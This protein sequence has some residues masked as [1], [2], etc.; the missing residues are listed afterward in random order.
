MNAGLRHWLAT[1]P[2]PLASRARKARRWRGAS[3]PL[4]KGV[5]VPLR[6]VYEAMRGIVFWVRRVFIAEPIFRSYCEKVGPGFRAGVFVHWVQGRGRIIIGSDVR[7]DGKSSFSFASR[8]SRDPTLTIG[9]R[10]GIGHQCSFAVGNRIDIGSDCRI[11]PGVTIFDSP[12]HPIDPTARQ[13]GA[14]PNQD[15]VRPVMIGNN[16]WIGTG[17]TIYPGVTIG[18]GS[19]ISAGAVVMN[20]VPPNTL[21]AGNPGRRIGSTLKQVALEE[22]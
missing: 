21:V 20:D 3:L 8:F 15:A 6:M 16:V 1:S 18:E 2:H 12:G 13:S 10:T 17:A 7:I 4:P 5:S 9:D 19:V 11:A 14:P 22:Q